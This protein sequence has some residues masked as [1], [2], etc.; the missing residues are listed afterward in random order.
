MRSL[1]TVLLVLLCGHGNRTLVSP[2]ASASESLV[3]ANSARLQTLFRS[4]WER[5]L[6]EH[7]DYASELGD[8]RYNTRWPDV[9]LPAMQAA[10]RASAE[11]LTELRSINF[12]SLNALDRLNYRLFQRQYETEI[13]ERKYRLYLMPLSQRGGIQDQNRLTDLLKFETIRDYE[14]WIARLNAFPAYLAQTMALMGQGI[15][16]G[17]LHP[18]VVMQRVPNQIRKQIVS[19]P[20]DSLFFKPFRSFVVEL[21]DAQKQRL[22]TQAATAIQERV[23]PSYRAF[24]EFFEQQYLP[25]SYDHA[26]CWQRPNG[27]EMYRH[28]AKR[29]TTTDLTPQQIHEIGLCEVARIRKQMEVIQKQ[30][31]F[32]G[33]F[34]EFLTYLRTDRQFYYSTPDELLAAYR[35]CCNRIDPQLP[36][37]FIHLPQTGYQIVPVP[38]QMAA[39][40][41][42]AYYQPPSYDGRRPGTYYVNLY[43]I[44]TRPKFEIEA[45]S[46]H[47]SVPGHH[48]QTAL[49]M[50]VKSMPNFRRYGGQTAFIEGWAL[51]SEKLGEEMGFYQ[52]PYSR[53]GQLTY[54]MWRAVRLVVD[55]GM[56]SLK[57]SRQQAI[58]FFAANTAKSLLDIENEV[59]RY[60]A[61]PG[62]ALAYKIGELRFTELRKRSEATLGDHFDVREFHDI[63]LRNGAVPLDIL[64]EQV[65]AWL[66]E[67]ATTE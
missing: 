20:Q 57:W 2:P 56:H 5:V 53:F 54:E 64:E 36:Q 11:A 19:Q 4:E 43:R 40:T 3:D 13:A 10:D 38:T 52:D 55:T 25:A 59:D 24:L 28:L 29:Y 12:E 42:T 18:K 23:I 31:A 46:L 67:K 48:L 6:K 22:R 9:S 39:D 62:Q 21:T 17:M 26:G 47:E 65:D 30:V 1:V 50:E 7:P 14:D 16:E 49:A 32:E 35:E 8:R 44:E 61:W 63:V 41:T 27:Q 15:R 51:Y 33:S 58:D 34:R 66:A 60:I 37:L 45:L